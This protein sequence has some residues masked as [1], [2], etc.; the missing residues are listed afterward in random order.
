[1]NALERR[2][3]IDEYVKTEWENMKFNQ[4]LADKNKKQEIDEK[5]KVLV[6]KSAPLKNPTF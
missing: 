4:I 3:A 5:P 2:L 1:M 6:K